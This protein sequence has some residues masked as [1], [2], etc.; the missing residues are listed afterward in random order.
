M[1]YDYIVI[2]A[3][4]TGNTKMLA[5]EIFSILPGRDKDLKPLEEYRGDIETDTY[6]VGFWTD[7]GS[8]SLD[9]MDFLSG[10]ENKN[11]IL[12]GTCGLGNEPAYYRD[13]SQTVSAWIPDDNRYLGTF[14]CQGKMPVQIRNKYEEM[15]ADAPDKEAVARMLHNYD[16]ALLHPNKEDFERA[17][18]FVKDILKVL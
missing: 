17:A 10:L 5:T 14:L 13:I 16:Q 3:S 7:H 1:K 15:Y 11:I 8:C 9:V 6:F 2:Y 4:R 12:F 18:V